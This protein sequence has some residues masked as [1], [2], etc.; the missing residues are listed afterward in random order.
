LG[1]EECRFGEEKGRNPPKREGRAARKKDQA[2]LKKKKKNLFP[3]KRKKRFLFREKEGRSD[4]RVKK[5][6]MEDRDRVFVAEKDTTPK[7][8][9][10]SLN[11]R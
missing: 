9:P 3:R 8:D 7:R 10:R 4:Y 6:T 2:A 5:E 1:R 11:R